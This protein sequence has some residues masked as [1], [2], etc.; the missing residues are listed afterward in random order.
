MQITTTNPQWGARADLGIGGRSSD[1][2]IATQIPKGQSQQIKSFHDHA[3]TVLPGRTPGVSQ[4]PD[5]PVGALA[6]IIHIEVNDLPSGL[7]LRPAFAGRRS[8]LAL[9]PAAAAGS[10]PAG[11]AEPTPAGAL[12]TKTLHS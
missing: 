10:K 2:L 11:A 1:L 12:F 8:G 5:T 6:Q 3:T 9:S 4:N 7:R